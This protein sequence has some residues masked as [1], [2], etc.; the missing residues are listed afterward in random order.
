MEKAE[1]VG[2]VLAGG[3]GRRIGGGKPL[4]EID[5]E[6]LIDQAVDVL[7]GLG[8]ELALV[9]RAGQTVPATRHAI[10]VVRD[11]VE[12]AGPLGGLD[13]LLR[14][15]PVEWTLI[16]PCDQP[17]L[18]PALLRGFLA[19][20]RDDVDAVI[21]QR[22]A[23]IEPL[24]GLYRRTCLPAVE[25]ALTRGERSMQNLLASLR[26]C[27]VP[28][29]LLRDWDAELLSYVNVNTP[30]DLARARALAQAQG[31][32]EVRPRC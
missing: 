27:A 32:P 23:S 14:W 20:P 3:R 12:D 21:G 2:A 9:L 1:P 29:A 16:V 7:H 5:G 6:R 30:A 28:E 8:L 25:Q 22:G 11:H 24:P 10:S 17:F 26:V 19:Q 31:Q 18:A 15:L 4:L 13:A